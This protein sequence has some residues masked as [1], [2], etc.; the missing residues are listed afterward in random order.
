V[1]ASF[2]PV[3]GGNYT[4]TSSSGPGGTI[5]PLGAQTVISGAVTSF[6]LLPNDGFVIGPVTGT[7]GGTLNTQGKIFST[8]P[9]TVDCTVEASFVPITGPTY[10]ISTTVNGNGSIQPEQA[11]DVPAGGMVT[12]TLHPGPDFHI[13]SVTTTCQADPYT[14][15]STFQVGPVNS[16]CIVTANFVRNAHLLSYTQT[17]KGKDRGRVTSN[18]AQTFTKV[19]DTYTASVSGSIEL[20]AVEEKSAR[21]VSWTGCDSV[22]G[23]T[24]LVQMD[25][26][27]AVTVEFY[28]FNWTMFV[29]ATTGKKIK[30]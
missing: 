6:T 22:V 30:P 17:G 26:D 18:P 11:L 9:I 2:V 24:C 19:G 20:T 21:F 29:P 13:D 10:D 25:S 5:L 4:V 12:F 23:K 14:S 1:E 15:G 8:Q 28:Y 3:S 16:D 7:C 27:R